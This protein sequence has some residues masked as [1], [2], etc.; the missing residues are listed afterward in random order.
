MKLYTKLLITLLV[1]LSAFAQSDNIGTGGA[2]E[3]LIPVF[4][5]NISLGGS[6]LS[7]VSG[8]NAI[9][10]N[11]AG[12]VKARNSE[13]TVSTM[14][15]IADIEVNFFG[16]SIKSETSSFAVWG[17]TVNVGD[18][19]V[20][21]LEEQN[22]T[23]RFYSPTL[24]HGGLTYSK[25]LTDAITFGVT[26]KYIQET[27]ERT[28]ATGFALDFGIQY[29]HDSGISLGFA[30][31]NIGGDLTFSG[32]NL[33]VSGSYPGSTNNQNVTTQVLAQKFGLPVVFEVSMGYEY[34]LDE[35]SVT[36][37]YSRFKNNDKSDN[38]I[39]GGLEYGYDSM[40]FARAG[41]ETFTSASE[42]NIFGAAF[43]LGLNLD[44]GGSSFKVDY[45]YRTA[46]FFDGSQVF[47]FLLE[48]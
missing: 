22:G 39:S 33:N 9:Q 19:E 13:A 46:E 10:T 38:L 47:T 4:A 2:S 1:S 8:L 30:L 37:L 14:S 27:I 34:K 12:L 18:I 5:R 28:D 43:G 32:D 35:E 15:Y 44:M 16:V 25:Q 21:T 7:T 24:F 20:T 3:L 23:G 40:F 41:Y 11:P 36:N 17:K 48:F 26:G 42:A 6:D 45:A 29:L 31:K